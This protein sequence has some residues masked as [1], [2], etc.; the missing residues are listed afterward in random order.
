MHHAEITAVQV[1]GGIL[2]ETG[3]AAVEN[4]QHRAPL[5]LL[6]HL[7]KTGCAHIIAAST[8]HTITTK[9]SR[10]MLVL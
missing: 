9:R 2:R 6:P 8:A 5:A 10:F 7:A 1:Q 4:L 3:T